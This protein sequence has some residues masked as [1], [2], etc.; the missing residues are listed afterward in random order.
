MATD[1]DIAV[2]LTADPTS[3]PSTHTSAHTTARPRRI[4]IL[5]GPERR[6]RW[7]W[8]KKQA[9]VE[10]SRS[11]RTSVAAIARKH[12]IGTGQLYTWRHQLTRGTQ[13][14]TA[15]FARVEVTREPA[16][17]SDAIEIVLPDRT[18]VRMNG[19]VNERTLRR[20]LTVL[21]TP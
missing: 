13:S 2:L 12:G 19:E 18:T 20:I 4:D 16:N 10:E 1:T 21:R 5:T 7:S 9:I 11:A 8:D 3:N 17:R 14:G 6:R 15:C